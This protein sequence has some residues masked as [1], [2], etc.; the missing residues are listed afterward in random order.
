MYFL[1]I[2]AIRQKELSQQNA[3]KAITKCVLFQENIC[4]LGEKEEIVIG[5]RE[6]ICAKFSKTV[7]A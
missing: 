6:N 2:N 3:D 5:Q 7:S 4:Y 1:H